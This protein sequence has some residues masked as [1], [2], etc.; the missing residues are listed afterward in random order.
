MT[1]VDR[2]GTELQDGIKVNCLWSDDWEFSN[3]NGTSC[4]CEF[5]KEFQKLLFCPIFLSFESTQNRE[6]LSLHTVAACGNQP[7]HCQSG[8]VPSLGWKGDYQP[9]LIS[10]LHPYQKKCKARLRDRATCR[11]VN[12]RNLSFTFFNIS[13]CTELST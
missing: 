10:K 9:N 8:R 12:S 11:G 4:V 1:L 2:N 6:V 7:C 5:K 3:S 13:E